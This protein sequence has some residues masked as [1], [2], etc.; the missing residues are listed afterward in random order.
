MSDK[1][2]LTLQSH[3]DDVR[4]AVRVAAEAARLTGSKSI[5]APA[6][7]AAAVQSNERRVRAVLYGD[8]TVRMFEDE[9]NRWCVNLGVFVRECSHRMVAL[10]QR[11]EDRADDLETTRRQG[12]LWEWANGS[13]QLACASR[14][15]SR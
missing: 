10:A 2:E 7:I 1:M 14:R 3:D 6:E 15:G 13:K 9:R 4:D 5:H 8:A 12:D 11:L